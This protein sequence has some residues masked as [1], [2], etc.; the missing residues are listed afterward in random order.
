MR[1]TI[2][3]RNLVFA[4]SVSRQADELLLLNIYSTLFLQT[5]VLPR[6]LRGSHKPAPNKPA[7][8]PPESSGSSSSRVPSAIWAVGGDDRHLLLHLLS[9][10][11]GD[12]VL[13]ADGETEA[14]REELGRGQPYRSGFWARIFPKFWELPLTASPPQFSTRGFRGSSPRFS[15]WE[16]P[17][18][19]RTPERARVLW[20]VTGER[21][22]PG[23]T[24]S[25]C[26]V[27]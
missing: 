26:C 2:P 6:D 8:W 17:G 24:S 11:Q 9:D 19:A 5:L 15:V 22:E 3:R 14:Q 27:G 1:W 7:L 25:G 12:T 21:R 23:P 16:G 10:P 4:S 20:L 18:H 13:S